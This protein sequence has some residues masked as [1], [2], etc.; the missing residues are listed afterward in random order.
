MDIPKI[1]PLESPPSTLW[2]SD[3]VVEKFGVDLLSALYHG[4]K[5]IVTESQVI[6][7]T[8]GE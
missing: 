1:L 2:I 6:D 8:E 4:V 5:Y 3:A 7:C